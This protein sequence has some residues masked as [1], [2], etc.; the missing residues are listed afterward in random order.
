MKKV[1]FGFIL[2]AVLL[3]ACSPQNYFLFNSD[4]MAKYNRTKGDWEVV[5]NTSLKHLGVSPDTIPLVGRTDS[6]TVAD[7]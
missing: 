5:W 6:V 2:I 1:V 4:M 3:S 7:D